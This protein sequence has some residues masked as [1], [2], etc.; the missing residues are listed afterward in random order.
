MHE[1][2]VEVVGTE[3]LQG[4]LQTLLDALMPWVVELGGEPDLLA[5]NAGV[6]DSETDFG[7]VAVGKS[8]VNVTVSWE[9]LVVGFWMILLVA[10]GG[11]SPTFAQSDFYSLLDFMGLGL[12]CSETQSWDLG[13]GVQGVGLSGREVL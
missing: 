9:L 4:G 11:R 8:C 12:P 1:V 2:K 10:G 7:F 13:A 5:R 3:G 6:L